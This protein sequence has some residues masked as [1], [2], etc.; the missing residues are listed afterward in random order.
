[1]RAL[2][3]AGEHYVDIVGVGGSIPP[4]PTIKT[5][6]SQPF[7]RARQGARPAPQCR[8]APGT[9]LGSRVNLGKIW[10]P[11]KRSWLEQYFGEPDEPVGN[12]GDR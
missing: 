11:A 2:S 4:A 10:A 1:M 3:S 6:S 9:S 8:N 12:G 7:S 5:R